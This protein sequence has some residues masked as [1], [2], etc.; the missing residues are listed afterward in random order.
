MFPHLCERVH[1]SLWVQ[2]AWHGQWLTHSSHL[3]GRWSVGWQ[4]SK[5]RPGPRLPAAGCVPQGETSS[6]RSLPV[7]D[8][9]GLHGVIGRQAGQWTRTGAMP[10]LS[11]GASVCSGGVSLQGAAAHLAHR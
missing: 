6:L 5:D 7:G 2:G 9:W 1:P 8:S 4:L 3:A 10:P 11:A